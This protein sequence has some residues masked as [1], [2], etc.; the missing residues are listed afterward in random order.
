MLLTALQWNYTPAMSIRSNDSRIGLEH[1][2]PLGA[3]SNRGWA[4][5]VLGSAIGNGQFSCLPDG[6]DNTHRAQA[7]ASFQVLREE[8]QMCGEGL[9]PEALNRFCIGASY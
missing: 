4:R 2:H 6:S 1:W 3:L 7:S 8:A 9:H 5:P